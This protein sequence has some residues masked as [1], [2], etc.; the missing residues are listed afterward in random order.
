M[1]RKGLVLATT[2]RAALFLKGDHAEQFTS[3][4]LSSEASETRTKLVE[5]ARRS[6]ERLQRLVA[7]LID[8]A[9][10]QDLQLKLDLDVLDLREVVQRAVE[11]FGPLLAEKDHALE[12]ASLTGQSWFRAMSAAWNR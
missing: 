1:D 11:S 6:A 3:F 4:D 7:D 9:R 8:V 5:N 2:Q 10:L 12:I